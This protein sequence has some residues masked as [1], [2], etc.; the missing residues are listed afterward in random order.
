M[1]LWNNPNL[2]P[3]VY[4]EI[5][6]K[7]GENKVRCGY[8]YGKDWFVYNYDGYDRVLND[9]KIIGWI[10]KPKEHNYDVNK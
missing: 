8:Y 9:N 5:I 7:L 2:K 10:N 1:Y 6:I 4:E 3:K